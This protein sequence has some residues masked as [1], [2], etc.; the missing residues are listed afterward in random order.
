[1]TEESYLRI[2]KNPIGHQVL[3][4]GFWLGVPHGARDG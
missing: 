2:T 3:W 1:M 4:K